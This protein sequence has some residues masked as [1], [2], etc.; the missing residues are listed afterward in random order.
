[1]AEGARHQDCG[2]LIE[3]FEAVYCRN[4]GMLSIEEAAETLTV[5]LMDYLPTLVQNRMIE[6]ETAFDLLTQQMNQ[7]KQT[8]H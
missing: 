3:V 2:G 1:M 6:E 4:C 8:F 7:R 5:P